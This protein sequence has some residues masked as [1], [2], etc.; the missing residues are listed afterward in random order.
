M[1]LPA[2]SVDAAAADE[3]EEALHFCVA[4]GCKEIF[5]RDNCLF[6]ASLLLI[7]LPRQ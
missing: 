3:V 1:G 7:Y 5:H 4:L 2:L 6:G